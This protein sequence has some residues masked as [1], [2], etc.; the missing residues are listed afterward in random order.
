[1]GVRADTAMVAPPALP[2]ADFTQGSASPALTLLSAETI[3]LEEHALHHQGEVITLRD[4]TELTVGE[5]HLGFPVGRYGALGL[6]DVSSVTP[7]VGGVEVHFHSGAKALVDLHGRT[8]SCS[9]GASPCQHSV[10]ALYRAIGTLPADSPQ[11]AAHQETLAALAADPENVAAL[12][13]ASQTGMEALAGGEPFRVVP[14]PDALADDQA[15]KLAELREVMAGS[16]R[17]PRWMERLMSK[18]PKGFS[19]LAAILYPSRAAV[20]AEQARFTRDDWDLEDLRSVLAS[21]G[22][23]GTDAATVAKIQ[24]A[25]T[26]E[27][28]EKIA[29]AYPEEDGPQALPGPITLAVRRGTARRLGLP[30]YE[31]DPHFIWDDRLG[32]FAGIMKNDLEIGRRSFG[33][34]GEPGTGKNSFVYELSAVTG[35]GV[36]EVDFAAGDSMRD[37]LG[38]TGLEDGNTV[39]RVGPL[40]QALSAKGGCIA[41][42]NEIVEAPRGELTALHNVF[43]SKADQRHSRFITFK[44]PEGDTATRMEVDES[45]L[46]FATWNPDKADRRP[47]QALARR[48]SILTF[49]HGTEEEEARRLSHMVYPLVGEVMRDLAGQSGAD[50]SE[51]AYDPDRTKTVKADDGSDEVVPVPLEEQCPR[52]FEECAR[53][54]SLARRLRTMYQEDQVEHLMDSTTLASFVSTILL[55]SGH[56]DAVNLAAM[57]LD[58]IFPQNQ[59]PED[60]W[61]QLTEAMQDV[62]GPRIRGATN[63]IGV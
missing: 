55:E 4:G 46:T 39:L 31:R 54:S 14:S 56:D 35:Q 30:I 63:G 57:K 58:F 45:S 36:F 43:G 1:M 34:S 22:F 61:D 27:D 26:Q 25:K 28:L 50:P 40:S 23:A 33:L 11:L 20:L 60:R 38:D 3:S 9:C 10:A 62:Y 49:D 17:T 32:S 47:H 29:G 44:S 18:L 7:I 12:L 51:W 16:R 19:P 21:E 24:K 59:S 41:V 13:A 5:S 48:M 52:L 42:F 53:A 8:V 37:L 2:D 6:D 15:R